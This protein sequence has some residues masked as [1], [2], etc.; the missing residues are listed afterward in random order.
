MPYPGPTRRRAVAAAAVAVAGITMVAARTTL[1]SDHQDTPEVEL[2]PRMDINDVYAFPSPASP[3]RIV[4]VMTTSSPITPAQAATATFD[5]NLLYQL[6]IDNTGDAV[7]DRVIQVTFRGTGADQEVVVRG[8]AAP[9]ETGMRSTLIN[10]TPAVSGRINAVL[11]SAGGVQAF[12]GMRDDPFFIDLE[13]FF[14]IIPDRR[15]SR[16]PLSEI[17]PEPEAGA[18]R[19]AGEAVDFLRGFN[20]LAIVL[21][22][23]ASLLTAPG[24]SRLGVWAT[25]SR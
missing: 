3:D 12:A 16:G 6:K 1:A 21:E 18:F 14:R 13:Q 23:P 22:M 10:V 8:P 9:A 5:P 7:E 15:P 20:T 2:S 25:I 11:G 19:P 4:L 17:G 24:G